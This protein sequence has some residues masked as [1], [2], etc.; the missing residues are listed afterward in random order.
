MLIW[1]SLANQWFR[2]GLPGYCAFCFYSQAGEEGWCSECYSMLPWNRM[3]CKRC[4]EPLT[5]AH[6]TYCG[7][8]LAEPPNFTA[9]TAPLCYQEAITQLVHDFKFHA[10]PRAGRLLVNLMLSRRPHALGCALLPVPMYPGRARERGFNQAQWL[11][12]RL[13]EGVGMPLIHA[14]CIK[15]LPSQRSLNR[16][17]RRQNLNGAFVVAG[18]M[19]EHVTIIDDVVTTGATGHALAAEV[20]AQGAKRVDVWA[21]ARTPLQKS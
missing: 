3:S 21:A 13:G 9:T 20:L 6:Q 5:A 2:R 1:T 12:E 11:A 19:P 14:R 18:D 17:E 15:H 10:S 7:H 4:A 8:C 16:K